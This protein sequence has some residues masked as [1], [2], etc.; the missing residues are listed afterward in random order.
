VITTEPSIRSC[1]RAGGEPVVIDELALA[2]PLH[3]PQIGRDT[4]Y[5]TCRHDCDPSAGVGSSMIGRSRPGALL[6]GDG[7]S[8]F[9]DEDWFA[10]AT[11]EDRIRRLGGIS[12]TAPRRHQVGRRMDQLDRPRRTPPWAAPAVAEA[13]VIGVPHQ[14]GEAT[15]ADRGPSA[16]CRRHQGRS[17]EVLDGKDRTMWMP[18]DV[19]FID[20]NPAG[21][22]QDLKMRCA[23][24][25]RLQAADA[26]APL[27]PRAQRGAS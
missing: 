9:G 20:P 26:D 17:P 22:P 2:S 24:I 5:R 13:A 21:P 23:S 4:T 16:R 18:D 3:S 12:L 11:S 15:A 6:I 1:R 10:P 27:S 14:V 25:S 8:Q 7:K 19:Q